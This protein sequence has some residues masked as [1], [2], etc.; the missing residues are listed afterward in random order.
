[1]ILKG[2]AGN[3][4]LLQGVQHAFAEN[5]ENVNK[6]IAKLEEGLK[7]IEKK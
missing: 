1:M 5:Y 3:K 7:K 2:I 6:E 4:D